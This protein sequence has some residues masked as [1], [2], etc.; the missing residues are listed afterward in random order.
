MAASTSWRPTS[1]SS[2]RISAPSSTGAFGAMSTSLPS[3]P[4]L[5]WSSGT[6]ALPS[7]KNLRFES[8]SISV[9]R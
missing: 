7:M 2:M 5:K 3:A 9:S 6:P 4:T 8:R 1:T